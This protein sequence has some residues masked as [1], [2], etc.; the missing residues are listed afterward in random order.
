M[1]FRDLK[2]ILF[3]VTLGG[4]ATWFVV[5][6][7]RVMDSYPTPVH[8]DSKSSNLLEGKIPSAR[9]FD[10]N[11]NGKLDKEEAELYRANFEE[12]ISTVRENI[13]YEVNREIRDYSEESH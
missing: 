3:A 4:F 1:K 2:G 13:L 12:Y 10:F 7:N 11:R 8:I 9:S 6:L 5:E